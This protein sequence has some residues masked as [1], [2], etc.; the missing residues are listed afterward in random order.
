MFADEKGLREA[1]AA[2]DKTDVD[3]RRISV[4]QAIPQNETAPGTPAAAL[5]RGAR[6]GGM[7]LSFPWRAP[8]TLDPT[9]HIAAGKRFN[10][11][12]S[13]LYTCC[14]MLGNAGLLPGE[15]YMSFRALC[16]H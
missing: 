11:T 4:T 5:Q 12:H 15:W 7:C 9:E 8:H 6:G 2:M 14:K 13:R 16:H 1:V 10:V 3:G